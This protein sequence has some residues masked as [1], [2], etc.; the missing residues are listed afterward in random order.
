MEEVE[1][2]CADNR[3]D[4]Y[5]DC[6]AM[7]GCWRRAFFRDD[8]PVPFEE[9]A[10]THRM[11]RTVQRSWIRYGFVLGGLLLWQMPGMGVAAWAA[12]VSGVVRDAQGVA[13]MGVLVEALS[14]DSNRV[15]TALTDMAG[16][17]RIANLTAGKYRVRAS[18]VLFMPTVL[19]NLRLTT[20]MRATVN[21]TLSMLSEPVSMLPAERRRPDEPSD[22]WT[23]TLRSAANRPILRLLGDGSVVLVSS[24]AREASHGTPIKARASVHSGNGG[25]GG[26]GVHSAVTLDRAGNNGSDG[27]L[28]AEV[29]TLGAGTRVAP[30]S[31]VDAGYEHNGALGG[32]SRMVVS[33]ASHPEMMSSGGAG[34]NA[35]GMQTM[36]MTSAEKMQLGDAVDVEAGG[37]VYAIHTTGTT[38]SAQPFLSVTVHPGQVWAVRYK[39]ATARDLQSFDGMDSITADLPVAA[40]CGAR[41][42][43]ESGSHQEISLSRKAGGGVLEAAVYRDA[44]GLSSV[45]GTGI[46]GNRAMSAGELAGSG[47]MVDTATGS[48]RLLASGYTTNGMSIRLSEPLSANLW[49]AL[50][51]ESGAALA[52]QNESARGLAEV[53]AGL[54]AK[55]AEAATVAVKGRVQRT[56]TKLRAS[57]RWQPGRLVTAVGPYGA[58]SNQAFLSFYV[59]QELRWG[60]RL[61]LG[62]E[63]T[64]DVTNLLA[65]GYQPFLS[66]DGRTLFLAQ[67]PRTIEGGLSFRF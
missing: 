38:L 2:G 43:T 56:G 4:D 22:D 27:V 50:E 35:M 13:Q 58:N 53:A 36:R 9:K 34:G 1:D 49:A 67:S 5:A 20:E 10:T 57:Y 37:T 25:F 47:T 52:E 19:S 63:A 61:P 21:L 15:G 54:H 30:A 42:C 51:Y 41:L 29:A 3:R 16:R 12:T 64:I 66:A 65:E 48:F 46:A 8:I 60:D 40:V 39:L 44:I 33:F 26:G 6:R 24:G 14:A 31:E 45:A 23:W 55:A 7:I 18:A 62:L 32:G 17:Y 28:R 59:G 11:M